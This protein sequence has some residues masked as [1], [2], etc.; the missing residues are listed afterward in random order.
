MKTLHSYLLV[1]LLAML[2]QASP[3]LHAQGATRYWYFG[4]RA[5]ME[6][7]PQGVR[8]G[9]WPDSSEVAPGVFYSSKG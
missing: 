2:L 8:V 7:T 6:F 1:V 5:M 9:S 3:P 4:T